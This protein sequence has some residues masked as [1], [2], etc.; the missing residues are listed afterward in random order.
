MI[1]LL[2][3][4]VPLSGG[5]PTGGPQLVLAASYAL[6]VEE[7]D[8][9]HVRV[10]KRSVDARKKG[11]VHLV[12]ALAVTLAPGVDEELLVQ[13]IDNPGQARLYRVPEQIGFAHVEHL[14]CQRPVVVGLGPAGLFAALALARA[15]A[16]PLVV[17]RGYDV[18]RR[19]R[20]VDVFM[21]GGP[22]DPVSNVQ[23]GEGGAGTFSDGKLTTNTHDPR[24][25]TVLECFV[26]HGAPDEIL[27]SAKPHIGTDL[28]APTVRSMRE[29]IVSLGGEVRFGLQLK[30]LIIEA[31]RVRGVL[32][33]SSDPC[34]ATDSDAIEGDANIGLEE[35]VAEVVIL[36][37]GHSARDTFEMLHNVGVTIEPKPFSVG[38]RVE[39]PQR[40]INRSQYGGAAGHPAL[41][42]ADY[43]LSCH[44]ANGR[45]VYTFCMCPGG[46]VISASSEVGGVVTNGMSR[47]AR[48][49]ENANAALLVNVGIDDVVP[50]GAGAADPLAGVNFQRT[51]ERAAFVVGGETYRAPA[52]LMGDFLS[53]RSSSAVGDVVPSYRRGVVFGDFDECL[54]TF[55]LDSLREG[56]GIFDR[57]LHGFALPDAVLTGVETRT[58]SS[59]RLPRGEDGQA[60][61]CKGL[62]PC[63]EGA[64]YAGGI[65]SAAVDGL[66]AAQ[67]VLSTWTSD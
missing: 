24:C 40:L 25:R 53:H 37:I 66:R 56:V 29:E 54:P 58:S 23:F 16:R 43:K 48:D 3:V 67:Q 28:L 60:Q 13:R 20:C 51:W 8:I 26:E 2:N 6:H 7:C 63:G 36:A 21:A 42:A 32:L 1:E 65:M 55:V 11:N 52:Q 39:H 41:G 59:V 61:G 31:E 34:E 17:E 27:Y 45:S 9:V 10:L 12:M 14:S 49:G 18:D 47:Y 15:G 30:G 22:L 64:G 46:E 50:Y 38:L 19:A 33:G 44:L 4:K 57:K 62:Y 35:V 5:L